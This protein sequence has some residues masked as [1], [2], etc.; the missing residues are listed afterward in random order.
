VAKLFAEHDL[1]AHTGGIV[2]ADRDDAD[3]AA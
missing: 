3:D 1:P 2:R